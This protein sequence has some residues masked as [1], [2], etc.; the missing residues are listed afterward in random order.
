MWAGFGYFTMQFFGQSEVVALSVNVD[1]EVV[2]YFIA[3]AGFDCC[4][5]FR[6]LAHD[7]WWLISSLLSF[8]TLGVETVGF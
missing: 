6:S 1:D 4:S 5:I 7:G 8:G 2:I 3:E